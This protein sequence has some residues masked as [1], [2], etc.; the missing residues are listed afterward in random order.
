[1]SPDEIMQ[2]SHKKEI[3]LMEGKSPIKAN[4]CYWFNE[5]VYCEILE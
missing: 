1:M 2:L 4:K 3:I 5:S